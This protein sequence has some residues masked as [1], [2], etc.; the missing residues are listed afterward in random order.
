MY[1]AADWLDVQ[2]VIEMSDVRSTQAR[3]PTPKEHRQANHEEGV[4]AQIRSN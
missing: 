4:G 3:V 1:H 2:W